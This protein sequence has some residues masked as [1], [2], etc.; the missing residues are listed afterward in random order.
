MQKRA[1]LLLVLLLLLVSLLLAM[2]AQAGYHAIR[3]ATDGEGIAVYAASNGRKKVGVLYNG[4]DTELSLSDTN[5]LYSCWLTR[6]LKVW[7]DADKATK[8]AGSA[9]CSVFMAEVVQMDAPIY[10]ST[11]HK[12]VCAKHAP[13]TLLRICGEL[14]DDYYVDMGSY[15]GLISKDDVVFYA[16]I[17][18]K[19]MNDWR[20]NGLPVEERSVHTGGGLL[21]VG[22]A[23]TGYSDI[24][25][26]TVKDR[27]A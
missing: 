4:Y 9:L 23:A 26:R 15:Q 10:T 7:L 16:D 14:G 17:A 5:G 19:D 12:T 27:C 11:N 25:P 1:N 24:A 20:R 22:Y 8:D 13:G 21:A 6:D 2:P 3:V 18:A